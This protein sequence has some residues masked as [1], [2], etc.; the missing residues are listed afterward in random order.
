MDAYAT[1]GRYSDRMQLALVP[2]APFVLLGFVAATG[3][4]GRGGRAPARTSGSSGSSVTIGGN[5]GVH[6]ACRVE[7]DAYVEA[8]LENLPIPVSSRRTG[9]AVLRL[10]ISVEGLVR[11]ADLLTSSG[12]PV[13]DTT[14]LT[15][16]RTARMDSPK[17][18]RYR[19]TIV[20]TE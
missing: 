12:F 1:V 14:A 5:V 15:L 2:V 9:V 7:L 3:R 20:F 11:S 4:Q 10:E 6:A 16:V 13:L 8:D 19:A 18:G 17:A